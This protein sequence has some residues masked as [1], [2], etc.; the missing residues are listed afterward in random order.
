MERNRIVSN[1]G[2]PRS[3]EAHEAILTAAV[4]LVREVGY[5]ATTMEGIAAKAGVGKATV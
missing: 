4:A 2:R 1:R 3:G 5:D